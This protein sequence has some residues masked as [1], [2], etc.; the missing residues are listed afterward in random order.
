MLAEDGSWQFQESVLL[1]QGKA[2]V[3]VEQNPNR[4]ASA[5]CRAISSKSFA[6][7]RINSVA[8]LC[9]ISFSPI[10]DPRRCY[11]TAMYPL[12]PEA[13]L[14]TGVLLILMLV[15]GVYL[16]VLLVRLVKAAT[17]WLDRH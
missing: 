10:C 4:N 5:G 12:S 1:F 14:F 9:L 16:F 2:K 6:S 13:G 15:G 11:T 17:R 3:S 8:S 7:V